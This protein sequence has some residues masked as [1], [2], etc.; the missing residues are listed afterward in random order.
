MLKCIGAKVKQGS[1]IDDHGQSV[2]WNYIRFSC[3]TDESPDTF[4]ESAEVIK[5]KR[6]DYHRITGGHA[7][8]DFTEFVCHEIDARYSLSENKAVLTS[9]K[10]I[11]SSESPTQNN[12]VK[13]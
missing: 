6:D 11:N 4:G 10:V 3:I 9:F 5:I 12:S 7:Y 1:M 2:E 8:K 13:K